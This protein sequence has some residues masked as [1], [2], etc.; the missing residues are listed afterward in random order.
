[1]QASIIQLMNKKKKVN[2]KYLKQN[3]DRNLQENRKHHYNAQLKSQHRFLNE[4]KSNFDKQIAD[5]LAAEAAAFYYTE[6]VSRSSKGFVHFSKI[7]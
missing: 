5:S 4:S 3:A 1:M 6:T 2:C 7:F